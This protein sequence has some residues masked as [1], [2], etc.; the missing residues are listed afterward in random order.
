MSELTE[1]LS[2]LLLKRSWRLP[3]SIQVK[4]YPLPSSLPWLSYPAVKTGITA[5]VESVRDGLN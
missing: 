5:D 1:E 3:I 2:S 4:P